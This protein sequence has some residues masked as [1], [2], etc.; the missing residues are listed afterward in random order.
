MSPLAQSLS[1]NS[2]QSKRVAS[3]LVW[4][5]SILLPYLSCSKPGTRRAT[6]SCPSFRPTMLCEEIKQAH[7]FLPNRDELLCEDTQAEV[8]DSMGKR[9]IESGYFE[10]FESNRM[11]QQLTDS[12][13]T[14]LLTSYSTYMRL[15]PKQRADLFERIEEI[16]QK[17]NGGKLELFYLSL[18]HIGTKTDKQ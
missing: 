13:Y 17:R 7:E 15:D 16:I 9:M 10:N 6:I 8:A 12:E 14:G 11:R 18:Y 5:L 1:K 4:T 2:L 3:I